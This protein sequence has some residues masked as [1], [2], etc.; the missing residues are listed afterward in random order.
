MQQEKEEIVRT[1]E[2]FGGC[3]LPEGKDNSEAFSA[4]LSFFKENGGGK[5]TVGKGVWRTGPVE[6]CSG[7][8]LEL[9]EGAVVS[10]IPEPE[11]Y[12]PVRTR[13]EGVVCHAMHPCLFAADSENVKVCGKGVLDG[14]GETWWNLLIEKKKQGKPVEPYELE[15][16]ALNSGYE[17]QPG[18]GGGR[19]TQFLRPALV[20]FYECRNVVLEGVTL[21][22]SPFW[23][24]HPVF[25]DG[26]LVKDV[27]VENPH[28]APNTDGMDI[29]SCVNVKVEGCSIS[30]GDDGI[31][32]KSGS[33][34]D[35]IRINRPSL[36]IEVSACKVA[37][38][39][40]GVVIGS[41][42]AA[43]IENV[44]VKDCVFNGTDR[45]IRL[46]T[47]R[48]R[49]GHVRNLKFQNLSMVNNLCPIAVNMYY[50]CGTNRNEPEFFSQEPLPV[51]SDTPSI[52]DVLISGVNAVGC[53]ASAG[54]IAGLPESPVRNLVIRDSNFET[55]ENSP[56]V[57]SVSDMFA[58]I[59]ETESK[60]FRLL[61]VE[62]TVFENVTVK[63][64]AEPF[65]KG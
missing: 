38:G 60:S 30:V 47:R 15:L 40:G 39:H 12:R 43:G 36:N 49:G 13:W 53:K 32:I 50:C 6:L 20:Q 22:N 33:G 51:H 65:L 59:P 3:A 58:G 9:A 14:S 26:L 17:N 45:G 21:R 48:G 37:D 2:S 27:S 46:K 29:D 56:E 4:A 24:I 57:P 34:S 54:F 42:T 35:G 52:T 31:A 11:R 55:D 8:T 16:A 41:E 18:G 7:M 61:N 23:T 5:L 28:N 19:N 25:T 63:G 1:I 64:P 44:I 62:D 10:F